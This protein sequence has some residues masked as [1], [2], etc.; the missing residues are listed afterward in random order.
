M[1]VNCVIGSVRDVRLLIYWIIITFKVRIYGA[2]CGAYR[3]GIPASAYTTICIFELCD[4]CGLNM[5]TII[6]RS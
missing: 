2:I 6:R 1:V 5:C 4:M 3:D